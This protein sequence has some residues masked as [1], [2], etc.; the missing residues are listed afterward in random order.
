[1]GPPLK[2]HREYPSSADQ[3][4][5]RRFGRRDTG[6]LMGLILVGTDTDGFRVNARC[7]RKR[8][9]SR[10]S[11]KLPV[12][13]SR[14]I[15][16]GQSRIAKC[17]SLRK[18][19]V[20]TL[21]RRQSSKT[22]RLKVSCIRTQARCSSRAQSAARASPWL[23]LAGQSGSS[24]A[25]PNRTERVQRLRGVYYYAGRCGHREGPGPGEAR[26]ESRA[27]EAG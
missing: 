6:E 18:T 25:D 22:Q 13:Q 8:D 11:L 5:Q 4:A 14:R 15:C 26:I 17:V 19:L 27:C 21:T 1:M 20:T 16:Q 24:D 23:P 2:H 9:T 3:F 10:S 7:V 12:P